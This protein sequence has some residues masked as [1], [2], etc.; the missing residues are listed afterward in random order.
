MSNYTKPMPVI[1]VW[2]RPFW[3]A[4]SQERLIAQRCDE[5]GEVWFPPSPVS[6]V[7]RTRKWTWV[8]LS[9]RGKIWSFVVFHQRYFKGFAD[10]I[11]YNVAQIRLEE[12]PYFLAN[13]VGCANDEL[14]IDMPVRVVFERA[15]SDIVIPKFTPDR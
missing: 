5:S 3:E 2:S 10:D 9:G 11:P 8:D 12:G 13:V 6:P 14:E 7:T 15:T 1:D 4:C